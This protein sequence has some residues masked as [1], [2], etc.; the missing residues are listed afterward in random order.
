MRQE[1]LG[2]LTMARE[3][4]VADCHAP[5]DGEPI[6]KTEDMLYLAW[7]L[8]RRGRMVLQCSSKDHRGYIYLKERQT[9]PEEAVIKQKLAPKT[10][11][12][13][14]REHFFRYRIG[15]SSPQASIMTFALNDREIRKEKGRGN[16]AFWSWAQGLPHPFSKEADPLVSGL[17]EVPLLNP[18]QGLRPGEDHL[19]CPIDG[20]VIP[21]IGTATTPLWSWKTLCGR[22]WRHHL[23]PN[24]LGSF[25]QELESMN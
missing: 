10:I 16:K 18:T 5:R 23:C 13:R 9:L 20:W 7:I 24:C 6:H 22:K 21:V 8:S 25:L 4:P 12:A 1:K 15:I 17:A 14:F 19:L 11:R 3:L 2:I